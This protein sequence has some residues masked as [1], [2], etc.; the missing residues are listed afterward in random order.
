MFNSFIIIHRNR[1][2]LLDKCLQAISLSVKHATKDHEVV[3]VS[4]GD[5]HIANNHGMRI[6]Q[7]RV[8]YVDVFWKTK[9]LN[10]AAKR[11]EGNFITVMDSDCLMMCNFIP[12][13]EKF[14]SESSHS[15]AKLAYKVKYMDRISTKAVCHS[16]LSCRLL[17]RFCLDRISQY[18]KGTDKFCISD[19]VL[20]L[21]QLPED[22]RNDP[23][24][25]QKYVVGYSQFTMLKDNFMEMGG[26]DE[27]MKGWGAED[28][29]FNIRARKFLQNGHGLSQDDV[30]LYHMFHDPSPNWIEKQYYIQNT[31]ILKQNIANNTIKLPKGEDWGEFQCLVR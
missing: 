29:D 28:K 11:S 13:V 12:T 18:K 9:A 15:N 5:N 10:F 27:R 8:D 6:K 17:H 20:F 19:K 2:L 4:L 24:L 7:F 1:S 21:D 16:G 3:L 25:Y 22:A 30:V 14:F 23:L 26:Y 31:A